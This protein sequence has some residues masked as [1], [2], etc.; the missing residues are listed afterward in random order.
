V[1]ITG[2]A[3]SGVLAGDSAGVSLNQAGLSALY[4]DGNVGNG[5]AV[6]ITGLT[7]SGVKAGNYALAQPVYV[8]G[9]I[10]PK[11]LAVTGMAVANKV[12][13][14]SVNAILTGTAA[15]GAGVVGVDSANVTLVAS[16]AAAVFGDALP[17][18]GKPVAVSGYYLSGSAVANYSVQQPTGLTAD[19]TGVTLTISG[20]TATD[21]NY[22][23]SNSATVSGGALVGVVSGD[24]V[25]LGG[26]PTGTFNDQNVG[27]GKAVTVTGYALSGADARKYSVSQPSLTAN[28]TAKLLTVTGTTTGKQYDGSN[29]APLTGATLQGVINGDKVTLANDTAGAFASSAVGSN[30]SVTTSFS[31][32]GADKDNYTV[33]QPTLIGDI[34]RKVLTV[35]GAVTPNKQ[36]DGNAS[37]SVSGGIPLG[38][39]GSE[40]VNLDDASAVA[41]FADKNAGAG[42]AVIVTGYR[43]TGT[44][45]GNYTLTQPVVTADITA[46]PLS[47]SGVVAANKE[48]D[49]T[50]TAT[51]SGATLVGKIGSDAVSLANDTT[52]TF[53]QATPGTGVAVSTVITLTGADAGN[54]ALSQPTGLTAD[55][56]AKALTISGASATS[57]FYDGTT[58]IAVSGGNL[59]GVLSVDTVTLVSANAAGTTTDKLVGNS[60]SVTVTGYALGGPNAAG[61]TVTQPTG[62]TASITPKTLTV[63][64]AVGVDKPFDGNTTAQIDVSTAILVGKE[65]VDVVTVGGG[66]SF[67]TAVIANNKPITANLVLGGADGGNYSLTQPTGLTGS[68]TAGPL[69]AV[70]DDLD[71]PANATSYFTMNVPLSTLQQNDATGNGNAVFSVGTKFNGYNAVKR[72]NFV[73]ITRTGG[74]VAG[75]VFEYTLTEDQDNDGNIDPARETTKA[76]IS[77]TSTSELAGTLAVFSTRVK[78]ISGNDHYEVVFA[79]MPGTRIQVQRTTT[80]SPANWVNMG[81]PVTADSNG[82]VVYQEPLA[83]SGSIF[84]RAYRAP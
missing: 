62:L 42:K 26:S 65:T 71:L 29:L 40:N 18:N 23:G 5:K 80:L 67:A 36:Y 66:G 38:V 28:I 35:S 13:N 76:K 14:N 10:T 58:I 72:G 57:R 7:L 74:F 46:A 63:T 34:T 68:I 75:D 78:S 15:L 33:T 27:T 47:V 50:T 83:G 84:F 20:A 69:R 11:T 12:Y 54:Y 56:S 79:T 45:I 1:V 6:A 77:F 52:G 22:D 32:L 17:G 43:I 4:A 53:A 8:T 3:L 44:D 55:I 2:G 39:V 73:T 9:G 64:G 41:L 70:D 60:K 59:L 37:A 82:Y 30:I 51:I 48:Y 21:K 25:T 49:G 24:A 31:L 16:S 19:I 61:Y 81:A